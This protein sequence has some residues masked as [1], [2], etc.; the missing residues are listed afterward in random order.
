MH[1]LQRNLT[2]HLRAL[3]SAADVISRWEMVAS[4]HHFV[5][6]PKSLEVANVQ[7]MYFNYR[8][9]TIKT[10]LTLR[11]IALRGKKITFSRNGEK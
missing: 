3:G 8:Q 1:T 7:K 9:E 2:P 11:T 10:D 5:F 4:L 6:P